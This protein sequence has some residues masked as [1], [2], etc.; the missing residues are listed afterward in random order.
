LGSILRQPRR[1]PSLLRNKIVVFMRWNWTA[2]TPY[3]S[4]ESDRAV[5]RLSPKVRRRVSNW[6]P[7]EK[8][9]SGPAVSG[10][11]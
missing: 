7:A 10:D 11:D 5:T 8:V 6:D 4:G 9:M 1:N 2:A 3:D